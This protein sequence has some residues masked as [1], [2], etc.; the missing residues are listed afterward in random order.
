MWQLQLVCHFAAEPV[1]SV[2]SLNQ[3]WHST[4]R[5][6]TGK[7]IIPEWYMT[8][9]KSSM[10]RTMVHFLKTAA[11]QYL[12]CTMSSSGMQEQIPLTFPEQLMHWID[13]RK[14]VSL[15][16]YVPH[17]RQIILK[18]T[19]LVYIHMFSMWNSTLNLV[20]NA[21]CC[22]LCRGLSPTQACHSWKHYK[23][24]PLTF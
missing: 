7:M 14:M 23:D 13:L 2:H 12:L 3:R 15:C 22:M 20:S 11:G 17:F 19:R 5:L 6:F 8:Y 10:H 21:Q 4:I 1:M 18:Y 9:E 16:S 24:D